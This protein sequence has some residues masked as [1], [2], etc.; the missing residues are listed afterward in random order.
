MAFVIMYHSGIEPLK[1]G[2][3]VT[4]ASLEISGSLI[5]TL[6]APM[7][8]NLSSQAG[9]LSHGLCLSHCNR[10]T[11]S[12]AVYRHTVTHN[13]VKALSLP[14]FHIKDLEILVLQFS[15]LICKLILSLH[16]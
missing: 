9:M 5:T 4:D 8:H 14:S 12:G 16:Q 2:R 1:A 15:I 10:S 13:V 3:M 7:S 11:S 6:S